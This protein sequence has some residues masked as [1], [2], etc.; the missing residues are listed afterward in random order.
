MPAD[1]PR[2]PKPEAMPLHVG[3]EHVST[4]KLGDYRVI[5]LLGEGAMGKV[6][7]A[8]Q[9]SLQRRVAHEALH[10]GA[11]KVDRDPRRCVQGVRNQSWPGRPLRG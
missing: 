8:V 3:G 7:E 5:R 10:A 9:E 11:A 1:A 2:A 4:W 6:Y